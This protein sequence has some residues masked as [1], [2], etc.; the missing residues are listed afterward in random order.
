M[1]SAYLWQPISRAPSYE[2]DLLST[3]LQANHG[4]IKQ[5]AAGV[6]AW[7]AERNAVATR[8]TN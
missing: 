5:V 4:T 6:T 2:F 8:Q 7:R 3:A 1:E